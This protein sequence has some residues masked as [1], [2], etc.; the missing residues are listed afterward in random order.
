MISLLLAAAV[1]TADQAVDPQAPVAPPSNATAS[2][3]APE[4]TQEENHPPTPT[5][6]ARDIRT[7]DDPPA[8]AGVI[9]YDAAFFA[10]ARPN[11]AMDM[12]SR[13]PGFTFERGDQVRGFAGA[14]GNV[15]VDG[16]RPTTKQDDL[17]AL[18]R[19]IPA[20]QVQRIEIIRGGATGIDMQ[21]KTV[22]ANVVRKSAGG[23]TALLA[24]SNNT[25]LRDGRNRAAVRTEGTRRWGD[26][27]LLEGSFVY[28]QFVDDGAGDGSRV[29]F[30]RNGKVIERADV[31]TE[32]DGTQY[33]GTGAFET[34]LAGGKFRINGSV[35]VQPFDYEEFERLIPGPG[36]P[37]GEQALFDEQGR[38]QGELG[39]RYDRAFGAKTNLEALFIQQLKHN[40]FTEDA[41]AVNGDLAVFDQTNDSSETI[42]RA[43][44]RY[45]WSDTLSAELGAEAALNSLDS[46]STFA[47]NGEDI[48]L[49][50]GD[51]E[52][53]ETRGEAQ[54]S[55][56][57]KP[58]PKYILEVGVRA[59]TST[60]GTDLSG[61]EDKTLNYIKPRAVFTWSPNPN[62]Q[63][64]LRV[65]REVG[66]LDFNDFAATAALSTG[67]IQV[68]NPDIVPQQAWVGEASYEFRFWDKGA[69][70]ATVRHSEISDAIDRVPIVDPGDPND[71][72]DDFIFDAPGNIG[73]GT[74]DELQLGVT[75]PLDRFFIKNGLIKFN[76]TARQSEV[77]DPTTGETRRISGQHPFDYE[78]HFTQDLPRWK[79]N[80][81]VDVYNRWTETYYRFN[82][83]ATFDLKTFV[84]LFAEIKPRPDLSLRTEFSNAG[85]RGFNRTI[86]RYTGPRGSN[87]IDFV[88]Y[89]KLDFGPMLYFRVRKTFGG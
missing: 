71:P 21:G 28:G 24:A 4:A 86:E 12:I 34:P 20:S 2:Q 76:G 77:T 61:S 64:R 67:T 22:L 25:V 19:R 14:A 47:F 72:S 27:K 36:L 79:A 84:V 62:N 11:T 35:L 66:Q 7:G 74:Q 45:R 56:T 73:D 5:P 63:V 52:V 59:E 43:T 26:G 87:P 68:G 57:W 75:V 78:F 41:T 10:D 31:F 42:G 15:L 80:W 1:A 51:V 16:Q 70:V 89:R 3:T 9:R 48:P 40:T 33:V 8:Q 69:I 32:G 30:D 46:L 17:E 23:Y 6:T 81:G 49:P 58:S 65:E 18:L 53:T 38:T 37:E 29:T 83:I 39:L 54:A 44:V 88:D 60:I 55:L 13:I 85:Q 50:A 82:E